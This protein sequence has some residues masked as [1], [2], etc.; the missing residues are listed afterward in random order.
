MF[1]Y[2][3]YNGFK[4]DCGVLRALQLCQLCCVTGFAVLKY[5]FGLLVWGIELGLCAPRTAKP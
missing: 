1:S 4:K 5:L 2:G 3:S